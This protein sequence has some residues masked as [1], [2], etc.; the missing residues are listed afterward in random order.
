MREQELS[1]PVPFVWQHNPMASKKNQCK[2]ADEG[3]DEVAEES[4]VTLKKQ[5]KSG[6]DNDF[7]HHQST[8]LHRSRWSLPRR[9]P[10]GEPAPTTVTPLT[11]RT[12]PSERT[13]IGTPLMTAVKRTTTVA[14]TSSLM[15]SL[16]S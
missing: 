10:P 4:T 2:Y 3:E 11:W 12:T 13:S 16:I 5:Q 6:V 15:M 9:N 1:A 7:H 14:T 8:M